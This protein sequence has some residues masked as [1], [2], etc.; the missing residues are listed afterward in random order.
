MAELIAHACYGIDIGGTKIELVACD[1]AMQVTWRRRVSTPQGDYDGFLQAMLG[2]VA[3]ADTALGRSDAAIGIALPGVRDRRTGRQLSAN[4]PALT[5]HSVA[6]DLQA[7]LQ[8]RLHFGNDLQCF[9]LS[10]AHGGA[11]EGYPSMFGAILGTGAGGGFCLQGRLLSG[12]NGL[13]GE[14]GHWS[15]PGHLLQ[16][17]GLPLIDCACGLQGCVERYVSGSG[18]AMIE[19]HLGG[20]AADAS[21]VIAL[22]EA[23][24]ARARQALDIHRDL[25]G[26]S[27][28]ALVLALDPHVIVLG[29]GLSQY[30]PLYQQLP[31]AISAHLFNGVQVPPIVPPRFGDAGGARGAALLACQPSFS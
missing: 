31:A 8:R 14:W 24:D 26:H 27:L 2:L 3:E 4:V 16:R 11:A 23:G 22:A 10:E 7:R 21:A 17:H 6:A 29:G 20:N 28:A 30:V 1:A 15:V 18:L 19:R 12:F 9:A 5:G 25:L 13:A